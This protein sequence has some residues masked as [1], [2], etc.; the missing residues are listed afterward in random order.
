MLLTSQFDGLKLS[1]KCRFS[2]VGSLLTQTIVRKRW[3][4]D[5]KRIFKVKLEVIFFIWKLVNT[6]CAAKNKIYLLTVVS[7]TQSGATNKKK[8]C[9]HSRH[10][11][12]KQRDALRKNLILSWNSDA[13][14][15]LPGSCLTS[16]L[17]SSAAARQSLD[18]LFS[19]KRRAHRRLTPGSDRLSL[20]ASPLSSAW[21]MRNKPGAERGRGGK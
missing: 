5:K 3:C 10:C 11:A 19:G 6:V 9:F 18:R 15:H 4:L 20:P 16:L 13:L 14:S 1:R 17:N 8:L 2:F 7:L 12:E 21:Q